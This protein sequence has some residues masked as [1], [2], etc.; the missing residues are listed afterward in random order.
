MLSYVPTPARDE[1]AAAYQ[2]A[3]LL[4]SPERLYSAVISH[5]LINTPDPDS[6]YEGEDGLYNRLV[7][8]ASKAKSL[9]DLITLSETKKYTRARIR[10]VI[11]NALIGVTSSDVRK[12]PAYT[13]LLASDAS[14]LAILKKAKKTASIPILTKPSRTA[15]LPPEVQAQLKRSWQLDVYYSLALGE[16]HDASEALTFTPFVK[17]GEAM[18]F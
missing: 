18:S 15:D 10:R 2:G 16:G 6:V 17:K 12:A 5:L 7:K 1:L 9:S 14:G 3:Q 11:F 8:N 4:L 13:Q